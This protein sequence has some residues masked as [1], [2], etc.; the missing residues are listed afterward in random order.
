MS[1]KLVSVWC[2]GCHRH[3]AARNWNTD[4]YLCKT[5]TARVHLLIRRWSSDKVLQRWPI[6]TIIKEAVTNAAR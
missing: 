4:T 1:T 2:A 3:V 6:S 5:C